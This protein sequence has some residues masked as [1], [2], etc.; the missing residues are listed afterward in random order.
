MTIAARRKTATNA[1]PA[2]LVCVRR[3]MLPAENEE[4]LRSIVA[5]F[6]AEFIK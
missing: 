1:N 4:G 6:G 5:S 3:E 2:A